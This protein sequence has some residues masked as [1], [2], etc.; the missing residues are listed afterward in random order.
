MDNKF[1]MS[2]LDFNLD[3]NDFKLEDIQAGSPEYKLALYLK[4]WYEDQVHSVESVVSLIE[5]D[6]QKKIFLN[7]YTLNRR[8]TVL[9]AQG[10]KIALQLMGKTLP[11]EFETE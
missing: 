1:N 11:I 8:D 5:G 2:G 3:P 4:T 6:D 9:V 10:M 7:S